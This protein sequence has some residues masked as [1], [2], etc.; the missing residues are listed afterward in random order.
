MTSIF[1]G[2]K[3][4]RAKEILLEQQIVAA[5]L[6][7]P[8][9]LQAIVFTEDEGSMLYT[10]L[11]AEAAE[12]VGVAYRKKEFSLSDPIEEVQ[13]AIAAANQDSHITG[14]IIQKP[15]RA[16]YETN[17][18]A[19][20]SQWWLSLVTQIAVTK[21][22]D[23]LHPETL[24]SGTILPATCRAVLAIMTEALGGSPDNLQHQGKKIAIVGRS[25]LLGRP[26]T[27]QLERQGADVE[28]LGKKELRARQL[29]GAK[30]FD[31]DVVVSATGVA[32]LITPDMVSDGVIAIDVGEPNPDISRAV[33]AKASFFT[34]VPGGVGPMTVVSLLENGLQI[35]AELL[36]KQIDYL[37]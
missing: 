1:D 23:G 9:T 26:L 27:Q 28:L 32:N 22:V 6:L 24:K 11:K 8:I 16:V 19:S 5:N 37:R 30:L 34:P 3:A 33:A 20:Y 17:A 29:S 35:Q 13:A 12:R 15:S 18:A 36:R 25:D 10:R 14:L 21:D 7:Q 31:S 2:F 4:A